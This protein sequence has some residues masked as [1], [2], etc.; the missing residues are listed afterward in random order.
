MKIACVQMNAGSDVA[1]NLTRAEHWLRQAAQ[2]GARLV[3]LP[4]NFA[5]CAKDEAARRALARPVEDSPLVH[6]L[7]ETSA[8]FG[9]ALI[10]AGLPLA[11]RQRHKAQNAAVAV[12]NGEVRAVY[13][14]MHLF[15]IELPG[16]SWQ[17]SAHT[18][19]GTHPVV[20]KLAGVSVALAICYDLRFPELFRASAGCDLI[21]LGA[22]FTVPTGRAHWEVLVRAR[23]IENQCYVAAAAQWGRHPGGR[24][25]FGHTMIVD[26]WGEVLACRPEGEGIV[27][28]ELDRAHLA[29]VR[30]RLPALAHRRP[31][32][33]ARSC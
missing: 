11:G 25:T 17:E 8:R 16:E 31:I 29:E 21:A 5:W 18:E 28:A 9:L 12:E 6:W 26:P 3:V 7:C 32:P 14:K 33:P 27:V 15:D 24:E 19:A 20:V 2:E 30:R 13:A 22:A 4:E 1:A 10:G 23:A